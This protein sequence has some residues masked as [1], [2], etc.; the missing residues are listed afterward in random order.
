MRGANELLPGLTRDE[1]AI[2]RAKF[3]GSKERVAKGLGVSTNTL[4]ALFDPYG[5]CARKVLER[6]RARLQEP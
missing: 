3:G 4:D 1:V 6:V 2:A 5:R